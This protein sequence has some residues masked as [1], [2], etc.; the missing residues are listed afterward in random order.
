MGLLAKLK[1]VLGLERE[2]PRGDVDVTVE[3]EPGEQ[4][5]SADSERAVK[6]PVDESD[7][8]EAPSAGS[9]DSDG[10]SPVDAEPGAGPASTE[11][12][13]PAVTSEPVA[14]SAAE[15]EIGDE[16]AEEGAAGTADGDETRTGAES[17]A[18]APADEPA[19]EPDDSDAGAA[20]EPTPEPEP[21][22]DV[23]ADGEAGA[24]TDA[25][26]EPV[27]DIKGIGPAYADRLADVD[28]ETVADLAAAD[29]DELGDRT[30]LS[31]K[32]IA[33]WIERAQARQR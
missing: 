21:A 23:G 16:G 14:E 17:E 31:P 22:S 15:E 3:R 18:E 19:P 27:D 33:G 4:T 8:T 32:R 5:P 10:E 12:A 6:E 2:E 1:A 9:V 13:E 28:V 20:S 7:A 30:D 26:G 11:D 29:A 24:G 25:A